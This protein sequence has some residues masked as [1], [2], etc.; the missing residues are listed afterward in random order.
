MSRSRSRT[1][2]GGV[3]PELLPR[4]FDKH[5]REGSKAATAS[6]SR[7]GA[8]GGK[9]GYGLGLAICKGLVEAHGGRIRAESAGP[10]LGTTVTFTLPVAGE[11]GPEAA[12][13][14]PPSP[15]TGRTGRASW[16]STTTRGRSARCATRCRRPAT[17]L[18]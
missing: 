12:A 15:A 3:A 16:W 17:P 5:A 18:W 13:Q 7:Q 2:G 8:G 10:G 6:G 4:L 11:P 14:A 9:A 1:R